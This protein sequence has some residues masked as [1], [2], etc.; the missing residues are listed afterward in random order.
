MRPSYYILLVLSVIFFAGC[1]AEKRKLKQKIEVSEAS[2]VK[3]NPEMAVQRAELYIEFANKFEKDKSSPVYLL[4]AATIYQEAGNFSK[5]VELYNIVSYRYPDKEFE[6][7]T[8]LFNKGFLLE[9]MGDY[10]KSRAAYEELIN[11]YPSHEMAKSAQENLPLIG[12]MPDWV[13]NLD[14]GFN[15]DSFKQDT[16]SLDSLL[17]N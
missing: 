5:A 6:A 10:P 8:A 4:K 15:P 13:K 17:L 11:K 14:S 7:G 3:A 9:K 12:T 16:I 2:A 1:N